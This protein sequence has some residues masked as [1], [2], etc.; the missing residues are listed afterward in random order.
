MGDIYVA[1]FYI[2]ILVSHSYI[3][4]SEAMLLRQRA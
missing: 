1:N 3:C 2:V 4:V